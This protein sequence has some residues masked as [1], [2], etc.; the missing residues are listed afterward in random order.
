MTRLKALTDSFDLFPKVLGWEIMKEDIVEVFKEFH[1]RR[2]FEK[3]INTTFVSLIPK[4]ARAVDIKDY[5]PI[6]LV[7]GVYKIIFIVLAN[8]LKSILGK[9][10]SSSDNA[11]IKHRQILDSILVPNECLDSWIRSGE[12]GVLCK[13]EL[14]KAPD[15]VNWEFCYIYLI[16]VALGRNGER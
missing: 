14:E 7:G 13:L 16:E 5:C 1:C 15:H 6:T 3:S 9:I 8:R 10:I 4:K 2:K 11:F 12:A